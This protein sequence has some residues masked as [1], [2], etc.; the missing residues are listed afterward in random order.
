MPYLS[1]IA[2]NRLLLFLGRKCG[3]QTMTKGTFSDEYF[4]RTVSKL[5]TV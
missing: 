1:H 5:F 3:E 4:F 2:A